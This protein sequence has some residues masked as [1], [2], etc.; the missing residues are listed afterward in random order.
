MFGVAM[1]AIVMGV[2]L[3]SCSKEDVEEMDD[4]ANSKKLT[5]LKVAQMTYS[6]SYDIEGK[7]TK[8]IQIY[9]TPEYVTDCFTSEY[10][11]VWDTDS[12]KVDIVTTDY[13]DTST[14]PITYY[15]SNGIVQGCEGPKRSDC[16]TYDDS[17]RLSHRLK[18]FGSNYTNTNISWDG[19]KVV[20]ASDDNKN[21]TFD[22]DKKA[23]TCKGYIPSMLL[24]NSSYGILFVAHPELAGLRTNKL[25]KS[26]KSNYGNELFS[27]EFDASGYISKIT[28]H[29]SNQSTFSYD[30]TWE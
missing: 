5:Q 4:V 21:Y 16:Y 2:S 23:K 26:Y 8:I 11:F 19:N 29:D 25:P 18:I 24:G 17:G 7:L 30:L 13:Y 12:I 22:Y 9:D 14:F 10:Y 3:A 1:F 20:S 28:V 15:L 6:F 27:Y